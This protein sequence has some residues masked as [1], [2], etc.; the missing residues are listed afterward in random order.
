MPY[1]IGRRQLF[2]GALS[3]AVLRGQV[4]EARCAL[5]SDTHISENPA[6]AYRGFTI[7]ENLTKVA[8]QVL[9]A[10]V[11]S[12]VID[13]D[14]AR[15]KG[16]P[17]DYQALRAAVEPVAAKMPV[18]MA[19]GNHDDRR[20]FLAAFKQDFKSPLVNRHILVLDRLPVRLVI[21]DSLMATDFV[22]GFLGKAQRTWVAQFL[23]SSDNTPVIF[24]VH[25]PPDDA[26]GDLLDSDRLL[27][28]LTPARKVKAL[29]YGHSHAYRYDVVDGLHLI[30][31]PSVGY[32]FN[33]QEPV[34]WVE[35]RLSKDGGD[36]TLRAIGGN[37]EQDRKTRSLGWRA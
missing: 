21:L 9:K 29:V 33:D 19:L 17:G 32:N 5:L 2:A 36:F 10:D 3:A 28:I 15:L 8:A 37:T 4:K 27:R 6:E 24:F 14:L 30:N 22:P 26:D 7:H 11:Q 20:N 31:V 16:L 18:A 13:G 34:G 1:L 23:A 12:M 35:T 25:H